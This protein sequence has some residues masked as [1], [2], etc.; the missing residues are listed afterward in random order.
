MH[1]VCL[2][3]SQKNFRKTG[4]TS[5]LTHTDCMNLDLKTYYRLAV[6]KITKFVMDKNLWTKT[7]SFFI[8]CNKIFF[9]LDDFRKKFNFL[10]MESWIFYLNSSWNGERRMYSFQKTNQIFTY[11]YWR[12]NIKVAFIKL[13]YLSHRVGFISLSYVTIRRSNRNTIEKVVIRLNFPEQ[14]YTFF[15]S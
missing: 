8:S 11:Q 9:D 14:E 13:N 3:Y 2:K 15:F 12:I 7:F 1:R 6:F 5:R 4:S 10:H